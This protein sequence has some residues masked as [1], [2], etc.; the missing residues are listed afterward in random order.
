V[1]AVASAPPVCL[2]E[3]VV[4]LG[5]HV[6]LRIAAEQD[7]AGHARVSLQLFG[8][9]AAPAGGYAHL[10]LPPHALREIIAALDRAGAALGVR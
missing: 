7:A 4:A 6:G 5:H 10:E 3:H 8:G 9:T 1:T 2:S